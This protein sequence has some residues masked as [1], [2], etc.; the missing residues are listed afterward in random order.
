MRRELLRQD[1]EDGY[2]GITNRAFRR[3][4]REQARA[5]TD[6]AATGIYVTEMITSRALVERNDETM[7]MIATDAGTFGSWVYSHYPWRG[8]FANWRANTEEQQE[9][10]L[11]QTSPVHMY[12]GGA[13]VEGVYDLAGNVWEWTRDRR[14][15]GAYWLKGGSWYWSPERARAAARVDLVP[16]DWYYGWGLRVVVVPVSRMSSDS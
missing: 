15:D 8:P 4:A 10:D 2:A 9:T 14:E 1:R 3:L 16:W 13:T 7:K 12:P 5:A 6:G 11:K